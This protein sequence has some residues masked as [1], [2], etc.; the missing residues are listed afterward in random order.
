MCSVCIRMF[1]LHVLTATFLDSK[2]EVAGG[3]LVELQ[4]CAGLLM[5]RLHVLTATFLDSKQEVAGGRLVELQV[6]TSDCCGVH[7]TYP[8]GALHRW[9]AYSGPADVAGACCAC[10]R[11][12]H[13]T[14]CLFS[15]LYP[16]RCGCGLLGRAPAMQALTQCTRHVNLSWLACRPSNP[17]FADAAVVC[18]RS[19]QQGGCLP[20][21]RR[22]RD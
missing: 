21:A 22:R 7:T 8:T 12:E 1:R 6:C 16:R 13:Q 11:R 9:H 10:D 17:L 18:W 3:R 4:V 2:Q 5:F 20:S 15:P 14:L 19:Y